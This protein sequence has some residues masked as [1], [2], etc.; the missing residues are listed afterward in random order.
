LQLGRLCR[1]ALTAPRASNRF[2]KIPAS[3]GVRAMSAFGTEQTSGNGN[4]LSAIEA[5]ADMAGA[6]LVGPLRTQSGH[7]GAVDAPIRHPMQSCMGRFMRES[8]Q[9]LLITPT[10]RDAFLDDLQQTLDRFSVPH[11][12]RAAIGAIVG[13]TRA[14]IGPRDLRLVRHDVQRKSLE[15]AVTAVS[16]VPMCDSPSGSL[17]EQLA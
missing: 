5:E 11:A 12:E 1:S 10:E 3:I 16:L 9:H 2:R 6:Q 13:S 17:G 15:W 14:D 4:H 7:G 8:H